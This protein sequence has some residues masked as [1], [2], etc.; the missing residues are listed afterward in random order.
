MA[1]YCLF[2]ALNM[3]FSG[4]LKGAGDTRFVALVSVGLAWVL[5]LLPSILTVYV[6]GGG[7]Y[8]LWTYVTLYI[9]ALGIVFWRR[10]A[11]GGW[12]S[13]RVIETPPPKRES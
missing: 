4:A 8:P 2:D 6:L 1:V 11:R 3:I 7:I 5:L 9:A 13:L 10:F 12:K